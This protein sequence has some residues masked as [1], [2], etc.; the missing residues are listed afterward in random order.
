MESKKKL[1]ILKR[2]EEACQISPEELTIQE[3][4]I[5]EQNQ[6]IK[7]YKS[8]SITNVQNLLNNGLI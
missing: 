7:K 6:K 2:L 4:I 1:E 3:Q 5:D 8:I